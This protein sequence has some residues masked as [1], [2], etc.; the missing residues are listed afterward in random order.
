VFNDDRTQ[1]TLTL[2]DDGAGD[3]DGVANGTIV[4]P[5]GLGSD[6]GGGD[7]GSGGS[8]GGGCFVATA[9]YGSA[10]E[11]HVAMLVAL[12]MLSILLVWSCQ[13]NRLCGK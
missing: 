8:S 9:A 10:M 12:I 3:D 1:V 2:I 13:R 6:P 7:S 11:T 4:D 5:S